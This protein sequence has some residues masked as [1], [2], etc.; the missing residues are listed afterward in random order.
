CCEG[1]SGLAQ[2]SATEWPSAMR[3]Q[4]NRWT[5]R[6]A[7]KSLSRHTRPRSHHGGF[8]PLGLRR[9]LCGGGL[10]P[11]R[12]RF[13]CLTREGLENRWDN[14]KNTLWK[15]VGHERKVGQ[16]KQ[17][18]GRNCFSPLLG[19]RFAASPVREPS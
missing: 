10:V 3:S 8:D 5:K 15:T 16:D 9:G 7:S 2:I 6:A 18:K 14:V 17:L 12:V 19:T 1:M 11:N 4:N 13:D